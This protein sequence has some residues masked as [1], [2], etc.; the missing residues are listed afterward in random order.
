MR[1]IDLGREQTRSNKLFRKSVPV[2]SVQNYAGGFRMTST[3]PEG[4]TQFGQAQKKLFNDPEFAARYKL[5]EPITGAFA[6]E[7]LTQLGLRDQED[8]VHF[9]D[10]ASGTGIVPKHAVTMLNQARS[11]S[12]LLE[13]DRFTC[14]DLAPLMLEALQSRIEVE[15]WPVD[16]RQ[17]EVS[18]G[19]M[20]DTKMPADTYT[21][22]TCSFG[23][24]MAPS[25][26]RVLDESLRVLRPGGVAGWTGW[27]KLGW[28]QDMK[29]ALSDVRKAASERC[30]DAT[31][32]ANDH[33]LSKLPDL[34]PAGDIVLRFAGIDIRQLRADGV[35]EEDLPRWD[36]ADFFRLQ[37]VK[38]GFS[39]VKVSLI[40]KAFSVDFTTAS[41]MTKPVVNIL[42]T[43]WTQQERDQL[44]G[45]DLAEKLE[46][47]WV[48][49]F[50]EDD[51][52]DGKIPWGSSEA[53]VVSGK[54]PL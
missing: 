12:N 16:Q 43:L 7:L 34:Q 14:T 13:E 49:R 5:G 10:L 37:V 51:V 17:I 41:Q 8:P 1:T 23:P 29:R 48:E 35:K 28:H 9:L 6:L 39:D 20:R 15:A 42:A 4:S 53:L 11:R 31:T 32:N 27:C 36:Q 19:D 26:E 33:K 50:K 2:D 30:R 38:A 45:I 3:A 44:A 47:W 46:E 54:K 18:V 21:H 25:P 52:K 24:L 40:E 22:V